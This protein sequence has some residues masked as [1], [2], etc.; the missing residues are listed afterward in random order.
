MKINNNNNNNNDIS[1]KHVALINI[2]GKIRNGE[3]EGSN[4]GSDT[5]EELI[6][7]ASI[8]EDVIAILLRIDSPGGDAIAS[9]S[10]WNTVYDAKENSNKPIV[11]S[12][13]DICASGGYYIASAADK[14][15]ALP[16]TI[17]GSIG[18][19]MMSLTVNKL[20][21]DKLN[22][23]YDQSVKFGDNSDIMVPFEYPRQKLQERYETM[24]D[25]LYKIFMNRVA[26]G[27]DMT[28]EYVRDNSP[29]I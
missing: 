22:I 29:N 5:I 13:G 12:M 24:I 21:K 3:S 7:A 1:N 17:T 15:F 4:C 18:V 25:S 10:I 14:I 26:V 16:A 19:V 6:R 23:N 28:M 8:N 9:E 20:L 11:V 27:R 2:S